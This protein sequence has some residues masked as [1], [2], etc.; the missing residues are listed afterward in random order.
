MLRSHPK[1]TERLLSLVQAK[2]DPIFKCI[3]SQFVS[4]IVCLF[5]YTLGKGPKA[6]L[7]KVEKVLEGRLDLIPSPSVKIRIMGR[8]VYLRCKRKTLLD[9]VNKLYVFKSLLTTPSNVLPLHLNQTF[10]PVI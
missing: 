2:D 7:F 4:H 1:G 6:F 9:V 5:R 3:F 10:P 8:K